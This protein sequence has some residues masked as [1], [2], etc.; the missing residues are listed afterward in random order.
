MTVDGGSGLGLVQVIVP[1]AGVNY[2]SNPSFE[3]SDSGWTDTDGALTRT[4]GGVFGAW[5]GRLLATAQN[6]RSE[7]SGPQLAASTPVVASA[8]V[9]ASSTSVILRLAYGGTTVDQAHPGDGLWHRLEVAGSA[10]AATTPIIGIRDGRASAWS[11]VDIDGVQF[12]SGV[13]VASTYLDGDQPGGMWDAA[14][15]LS[16]SRRNSRDG[17]GGAISTLDVSGLTMMSVAG[18]GTPDVDV[19]TQDLAIKD[20]AV[21]Q[22]TTARA[23]VMTLVGRAQTIGSTVSGLHAVRA[24]VLALLNPDKRSNRGP[25]GLR[26]AGTSVVKRLNAYYEGGLEWGADNLAASENLP[27]RFLA[28]DPMWEGETDE[29][30][31]LAA[32][33]VTTPTGTTGGILQRD[34]DGNWST[35]N[36]GISGISAGGSISIIQQG[37]DGAIYA[38][39]TFA[40]P[41]AGGITPRCLMKW[42]PITGAWESVGGVDPNGGVIA[43]AIDPGGRIAIGGVFTQVGAVANTNRIALYNGSA[44]VTL[45]DAN[46]DVT[47]LA[48]DQNGFLWATGSFTTIGGVAATRTAYWNGSAWVALTAAGVEFFNL[49]LGPDGLMY[50][51]AA[52]GAVRYVG[53][54]WTS[55]GGATGGS[56]N[57]LQWGPRG[58]YAAGSFTAIGGIS[59]A[60]FA[61]WNA[62]SW[63]AVARSVVPTA[64]AF[65]G[66]SI[67]P[68]GRVY[69]MGV[70]APSTAQ[71][72]DGAYVPWDLVVNQGPQSWYGEDIYV[73]AN[74]DGIAVLASPDG[75]L[76]ISYSTSSGASDTRIVPGL[77][78]VTNSG[79][80]PAYPVIRFDGAQAGYIYSLVNLTTKQALRFNLLTKYANEIVTLDLRW[81]RKTIRSTSRDLLSFVLPGSDLDTF[82]LAPGANRLQLF[83]SAGITTASAYWRPRY[84]SADG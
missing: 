25:I 33:T 42:N 15:G 6:G 57:S 59:A 72:L 52:T 41:A 74:A 44:W 20:G 19:A 63:S 38:A 31:Q 23:R 75:R 73:G 48:W 4:A 61:V 70:V 34:A 2:V 24:S 45:G 16:V 43:M 69:A 79:S 28:P 78:T 55:I 58:L 3:V 10:V 7:F 12:E 18:I 11:N 68:D 50:G 67:A 47:G 62:A 40:G 80:A 46:G 49:Q 13:T 30:A 51:S 64:Q 1:A 14:Q 17:R 22:R 8:W 82:S 60:G 83:S 81:Q 39:G 65:Q 29:Q 54:A 35:M 37:P 27:L 5:M 56:L 36:G 9:Q 21:Y 71:Q 84:W 76:T 32:A 66:I 26:Y 53:G 77:T